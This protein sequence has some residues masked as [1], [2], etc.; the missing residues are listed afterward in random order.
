MV[1]RLNAEE[2]ESFLQLMFHVFEGAGEEEARF[3]ETERERLGCFIAL[4]EV[5]GVS[6]AKTTCGE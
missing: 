6:G 3:R 2:K 5:L 1:N 4:H